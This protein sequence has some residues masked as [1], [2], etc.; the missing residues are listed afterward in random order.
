M[1]VQSAGIARSLQRGVDR[2]ER[3]ADVGRGTGAHDS[4]QMMQRHADIGPVV[5]Q[6]AAKILQMPA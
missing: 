1:P 5:A 2:I 3:S 6:D 4:E